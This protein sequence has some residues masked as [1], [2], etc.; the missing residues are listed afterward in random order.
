MLILHCGAWAM[1][2]SGCG[3]F[4]QFTCFEHMK[5]TSRWILHSEALWTWKVMSVWLTDTDEQWVG[6]AQTLSYRKL[7]SGF[8]L[9]FCNWCMM[10]FWMR[11][12]NFMCYLL[13]ESIAKTCQDGWNQTVVWWCISECTHDN[14][15]GRK[16]EKLI[17]MGQTFVHLNDTGW[18]V[19]FIKI[20]T[21]T[22]TLKAEHRICMTQNY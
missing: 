13:G 17:R 7:R 1:R 16:M 3:L 18:A 9:A 19:A 2:W 20:T 5:S 22:T 21:S 6:N 12:Q 15:E 11:F 10:N 8:T 14:P 4:V